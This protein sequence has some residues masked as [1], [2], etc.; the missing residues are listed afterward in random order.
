MWY[1]PAPRARRNYQI[2][3][4]SRPSTPLPL[5]LDYAAPAPRRRWYQVTLVELL[6]IIGIIAVL[7]AFLLPPMHDGHPS[8]GAACAARLR[9]IAM[10]VYNYANANGGDFPDSLQTMLSDPSCTLGANSAS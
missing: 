9:Q 6:V 8:S 4:P 1:N 3:Q 10:Q 2:D 7:V 5:P